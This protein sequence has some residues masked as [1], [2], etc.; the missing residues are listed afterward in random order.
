MMTIRFERGQ[1]T[2]LIMA[3]ARDAVE[4]AMMG[5]TDQPVEQ[6]STGCLFWIGP[7]QGRPV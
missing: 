7:V 1:P 2:L 3:K 5:K 6:D 4:V